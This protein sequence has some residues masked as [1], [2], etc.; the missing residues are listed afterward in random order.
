MHVCVC[1]ASLLARYNLGE[2]AAAL[3]RDRLEGQTLWRYHAML[4]VQSPA[5]V[6]SRGGLLRSA[7]PYLPH[8]NCYSNPLCCRSGTRGAAGPLC[9]VTYTA[10]CESVRRAA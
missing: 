1:G 5:E 9:F 6:V 10:P 8:D 7:R 3:D 4:P 2:A